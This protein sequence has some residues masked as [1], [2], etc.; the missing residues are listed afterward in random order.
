M[1][2]RRDGGMY[3]GM[4]AWGHGGMGAW[5]H[6]GM[7]NEKNR[8]MELWVSGCMTKEERKRKEGERR[9]DQEE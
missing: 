1:E 7:E 9:I 5:G 6:G 4:G 8:E 3:G 2:V